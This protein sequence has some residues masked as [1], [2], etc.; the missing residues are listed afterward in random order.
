MRSC[1]VIS[2]DAPNVETSQ[3]VDYERLQGMHVLL[4]SRGGVPSTIVESS[5]DVIPPTY[6]AVCNR[7]GPVRRRSSGVLITR[8]WFELFLSYNMFSL[9]C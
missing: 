5:F 6:R 3:V 4:R 8:Y 7:A 9:L 2:S 1:L